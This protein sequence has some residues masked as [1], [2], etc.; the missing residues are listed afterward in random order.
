MKSTEREKKNEKIF[1][2]PFLRLLFS[3][4]TIRAGLDEVNGDS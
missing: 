4:F 1:T 3:I 2:N